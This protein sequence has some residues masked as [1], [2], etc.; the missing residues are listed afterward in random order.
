M[1]SV[2]VAHKHPDETHPFGHHRAEP[3]GGLVAAVVAILLA[4]E[5][6]KE[7]ILMI[8]TPHVIVISKFVIFVVLF[9]ILLKSVMFFYFKYVSKKHNS[10]AINAL[11]YDSIN[12]VL[13]TLSV[14][15]GLVLYYFKAPYYVDGII[16]VIIGIWIIRNAMVIGLENMNY[17]MGR[18]PS[19]EV[20][21]HIISVTKS[22]KG[23]KGTN[24]VFAHFVGPFVHVEIHVEVDRKMSLEK[25]HEIGNTVKHKL[26]DI[27]IVD[28]AFVH[29]DPR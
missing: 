15:I 18:R 6:I 21:E 8:F 14:L 26:Q 23:V 20:V 28:R 1:I 29:I 17:L 11:S 12:D 16:G 7:S 4:F 22:I 27:G 3:I 9:T 13:V 5:I 25:A 2:R 10:P 19:N 24:D